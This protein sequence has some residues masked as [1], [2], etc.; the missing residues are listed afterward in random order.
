MEGDKVWKPFSVGLVCFQ[1]SLIL[2]VSLRNISPHV[3]VFAKV[4]RGGGRGR[5]N[6]WGAQPL[7][8][9]V[10]VLLI[11]VCWCQSYALEPPCY[12]VCLSLSTPTKPLCSFGIFLPLPGHFPPDGRRSHS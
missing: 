11:R 7:D 5:V 8:T 2:H 10:C 6:G 9:R 3:S 1:F 4:H 12:R